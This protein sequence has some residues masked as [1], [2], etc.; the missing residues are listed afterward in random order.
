MSE[1]TTTTDDFKRDA[2]W[3][4][5]REMLESKKRGD[6]ITAQEIIDATGFSS[7]RSFGDRIRRWSDKKGFALF[8]VPNDGWRIGLA[9][10]HYDK[11]EGYR[12]S[13]RRKELRAFGVLVSTPA[14]E[15]DDRQMRRHQA[16]L[17]RAQARVEMVQR[18]HN[19]L[20]PKALEERPPM[21]V[22][23][24]GAEK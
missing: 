14:A 19:E 15:L 12:K 20:K 13:A 7:W 22:L 24:E 16:A 4:T 8:F 1:D 3:V 18:H 2:A 10:E 23:G 9:H 6:R 21:R 5:L 11:Q 17:V